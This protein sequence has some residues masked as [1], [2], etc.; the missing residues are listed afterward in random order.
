MRVFP[1]NEAGFN[2]ALATASA[3]PN[4]NTKRNGRLGYIYNYLVSPAVKCKTIVVEENY[5]DGDFLHDY[6][7]YY[8]RCFGEVKRTCA[9]LHFF[10]FDFTEVEFR[11]CIIAEEMKEGEG[12]FIK[13]LKDEY[14]GYVVIKPLP[15][16][17]V[18]RTCLYLYSKDGR[19]RFFGATHLYETHVA[20][21]EFQIESLAF[22]EQ[23]AVVAACATISLWSAF[24]QISNLFGTKI[25]AP[26]EI[27]DAASKSSLT[28]KRKM[29][30]QGL[31]SFQVCSA[32]KNE[33]LEFELRQPRDAENRADTL[34]LRRYV[35]AYLGCKLPVILL[36]KFT[37]N[38]GHAITVAGYS[39]GEVP[40]ET[41]HDI[42]LKADYI[43]KFYG[44]DDQIGPFAK[45]EFSTPGC[46]D[47]TWDP[48]EVGGSS[49]V[50]PWYVIIPVYH[51]IRIRYE[52]VFGFVETLTDAIRDIG[53]WKEEYEWDIQLRRQIDYKKDIKKSVLFSAS[54]KFKTLTENYP[55]FVWITSL[56]S[57]EVKLLDIVWDATGFNT[58]DSSSLIVHALSFN[59][60]GNNIV[61]S[62]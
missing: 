26:S 8:A 39:R 38:K 27:T 45:M 23:D 35:A 37:D 11:D 2:S 17:M 54:E 41:P 48:R 5:T 40:L 52:N 49:E 24:H 58:A 18:G 21:I 36:I 13:A 44:H 16:A 60:E 14:L 29:P 42:P 51:K 12:E 47:T 10:G 7:N 3:E 15:D 6:V 50:I 9:R 22:Q 57:G 25:P 62:L 56:F 33:G 19:S 34:L 55:R 31:N 4:C 61:Q 43:D 53:L 46:L 28:L 1:F 30:S 20:G 32:I 59:P